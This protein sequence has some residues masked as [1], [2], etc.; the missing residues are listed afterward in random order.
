MKMLPESGPLPVTGNTRDPRINPVCGD[1]ISRAFKTARAGEILREVTSVRG[2]G[3]FVFFRRDNGY[4]AKHQIV[5]IEKWR[6]W[7][8]HA[9]IFRIAD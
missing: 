3:G 8:K 7:A 1:G 2:E 4:E 6:R 9:T 5:S